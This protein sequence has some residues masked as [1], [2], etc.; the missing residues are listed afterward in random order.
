MCLLMQSLSEHRTASRT[1]RAHF[2]VAT[3]FEMRNISRHEAIQNDQNIPRAILIDWV[4][5]RKLSPSEQTLISSEERI[6]E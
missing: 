1:V 3:G 2:V 6:E 5:E 4:G